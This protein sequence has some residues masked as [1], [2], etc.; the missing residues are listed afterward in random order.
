LIVF[1]RNTGLE[2]HAERGIRLDA[3]VTPELLKSIFFPGT[4]LHDGSVIIRSDRV[5]AAAVLLPLSKSVDDTKQVLGA[6]HRAALSITE[7]TD[8]VAVVVSEETGLISVAH[9]GRLIRGL[10]QKRLVQILN[11]FFK[12]QLESLP[13]WRYYGQNIRKRLRLSR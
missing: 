4:A 11:A 9:N 3:V 8:A 10:D 2:D 1:E 7:M 12:T 6:R 5:I 13:R